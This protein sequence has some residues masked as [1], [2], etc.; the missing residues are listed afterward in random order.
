MSF[1]GWPRA[2]PAYAELH[3]APLGRHMSRV[4][5]PWPELYLDIPWRVRSGRPLPLLLAWTDAHRFPVRLL[6]LDLILCSPGG[7][8]SRRH[9][10]L[11]L[12]LDGPVGGRVVAELE[13]EEPGTWDLWVD[14]RVERRP[15]P[16]GA[17]GQQL[18]FRNHLAP[19]LPEEPLRVRVDAQAL[20]RWPGLVQGDP[21]VHSSGTRDMVE[22][23]PPP[24]LL[25]AA[26]QALELDWFALTDH[27]YDLDD[28]VDSWSRPDPA[29]PAWHAQ[30]EWIRSAN[31]RPGPYVLAGEECSVGGR[32]G[33][34]LHVL[35][36]NPPRFFPGSADGGERGWPRASEWQLGPLMEELAGTGAL[37]ISAHTAEG[38]GR[39]ERVL[40]RRRAWSL[41]DMR[42]LPAHQ[43]LSGGLGEDFRQGRR[44]WV[45][46]MREGRFPGVLAGGDSH[47]NFSLGRHLR[48]PLLRVGWSR[49]RLFGEFRS[50]VLLPPGLLHPPAS[51]QPDDRASRL[52]AP[53]ESGGTLL[54]NGP[55]LSFVDARDERWL[56]GRVAGEGPLR[57]E[58]H[59]CGACGGSGLVR[60][61]AGNSGGERLV[62]EERIEGS[63]WSRPLPDPWS[64]A[65]WLRAE[66][67]QG[68]GFAMTN[69][70][71]PA[72]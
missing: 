62:W 6:G 15:G 29:L 59:L 51:T 45:D 11:D 63:D 18:T 22:F 31:L 2:L 37:A 53:L 20:P 35:L 41:R 54:S 50:C 38:P 28:A 42:L 69:A 56:G 10:E 30:Q 70:L 58:A 9:V 64:T 57:L 33:G 16:W 1:C 21:H 27:S 14:G 60:L 44:A 24:E 36:L 71:R 5:Q 43:I 47:G 8:L 40:L 61:W 23:G 52:L 66:L 17:T 34:V 7:N 67:E 39:L 32:G 19:G 65:Q 12:E 4:W 13:L 68:R 49:E 3:Y 72:Q 48:T 46:L 25:Q 26:A 55:L